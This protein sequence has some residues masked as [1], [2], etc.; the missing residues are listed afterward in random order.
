MSRTDLD[1]LGYRGATVVL[2]GGASGMGEAVTRILGELGAV[3]HVAD[4]TEP[5]VPH[6]SF[7]RTDLSDPLNVE[8][9]ARQFSE[10]GP[11][12]HLFPIAGIPPHTLGPL[13]C[14]MI[15]YAGTRQFTELMLP[16]VKDGGTVCLIASTAAR[17]W[18]QHLAECL[19]ILKLQTPAEIRAFFEANPDA[20]HDGYSP[21]KELLIVWVQ[22]IAIELA[23]KHRI[24]INCI[25]P[26][27]TD[28]PFMEETG[29][30]LGQAFIDN[31][32]SP[33]LGRM[34]TAEE[35]AWSLIALSS[36]LNPSVTGTTLMTDQG[37]TG[38]MLTGALEPLAMT[39]KK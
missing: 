5:G 1:G 11:I 7:V 33:L 34:P 27:A 3:V 14:M 17:F 21:S 28:T 37:Y 29:K 8:T 4:I 23:R 2:T 39:A 38:G 26:C 13:E 16:S 18:Q 19:E 9:S 12:D 22:Q 30:V 31:Y 32:P 10:V 20:L 15:N 6:A 25:G 24:R 36:R 35:Q